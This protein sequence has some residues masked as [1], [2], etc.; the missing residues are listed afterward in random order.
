MKNRYTVQY[1]RQINGTTYILNNLT[2]PH[3][4][5]AYQREREL[6]KEFGR[7]NVWTVDNLMEILV[8]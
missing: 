4:H 3:R 5:L 7:D 8:G 6:Q 1:I 2:T